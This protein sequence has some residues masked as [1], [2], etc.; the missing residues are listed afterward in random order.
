MTDWIVF[1]E[2]TQLI[3]P[4][5]DGL[6]LPVIPPPVIASVPVPPR[7]WI[8]FECPYFFVGDTRLVCAVA[9]RGNPAQINATVHLDGVEQVGRTLLFQPEH[10][11]LTEALTLTQTEIKL[12]SQPSNRVGGLGDGFYMLGDNEIITTTGTGATTNSFTVLRGLADTVPVEHAAGTTVWD[13]SYMWFSM[14]IARTVN[15]T[16][17]KLTS[18]ATQGSESFADA[19]ARTINYVRRVEQPLCVADVTI[20][21]SQYPTAVTND[22][23]VRAVS[24]DRD[25]QTPAEFL[26]WYDDTHQ[27]LPNSYIM[28]LDAQ[29]TSAGNTR[30]VTA[31]RSQSSEALTISASDVENAIGSQAATIDLSVYTTV[32]ATARS[33]STFVVS[34]DW[35]VDA[36]VVLRF[37]QASESNRVPPQ[38]L[39]RFTDITPMPVTPPMLPQTLLRFRLLSAAPDLGPDM[40]PTDPMIPSDMNV[41]WHYNW[42][43]D[44]GN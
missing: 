6:G 30:N 9:V 15:S 7:E 14:A 8:V 44:W 33:F 37:R 26:G 35:S 22:I 20:N 1:E 21:G 3:T 24:R 31:A 23:V 12:S 39:L 34:F 5:T 13:L 25:R 11:E 43:N 42:G 32:V 40:G 28:R 36:G 18:N 19:E 17:V 4:P 27:P 29:V 16:T 2:G 41:G 10:L 38:T